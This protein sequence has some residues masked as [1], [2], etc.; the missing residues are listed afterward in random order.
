MSNGLTTRMHI[1]TAL[2]GMA[3]LAATAGSAHAAPLTWFGSV[4]GAPTGVSLD[5]LDWLTLGSAGGTSALT[6]LVINFTPDAAAV[7]GSVASQYAAPY[8][9]GDNGQGFGTPDQ[10][11]GVNQ[12]TYITAGSTGAKPDAGVEII[13][14]GQQKYFGLLWGSV[15]T[16]NTLAFYS[17]ATLVGSLTGGDVLAG[18]NG[19]QG[20]NGTLYVNINSTDAFDRIIATSSQFAFEFDN[21]AFSVD[22]V[23]DPNPVPEPGSLVLLGVGLAGM[24]RLIRRRQS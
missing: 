1:K 5:N 4:G 14:P 19:D 12:S 8:L 11:N 7:Q 3:L 17:G 23:P 9:S 2:M 13:L 21:L 15:D 16:Y 20:V 6:G 10:P 24:G 22:P 18:A